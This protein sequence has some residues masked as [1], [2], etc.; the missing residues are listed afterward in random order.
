MER[1][2]GLEQWG[3]DWWT[4]TVGEGLVDSNRYS[5]HQFNQHDHAC[6]FHILYIHL[7]EMYVC[8]HR[9]IT[10]LNNACVCT[11][12]TYVCT[13]DTYLPMWLGLMGC[14]HFQNLVTAGT[15]DAFVHTLY[16]C[17]SV[18]ML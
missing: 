14:F 7:T 9:V 13:L 4:I 8:V 10:F 15:V 12:S 18:H 1:A 17:C 3:R 2:G 11:S 16:M 5:N 6:S